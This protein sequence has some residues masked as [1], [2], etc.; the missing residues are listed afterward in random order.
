[1][2][3]LNTSTIN[4]TSK[5]RVGKTLAEALANPKISATSSVLLILM[6]VIIVGN[7]LVFRTVFVTRRLHFSAFYLVAS[8]AIADLMVGV[9]LLPLSIAYTIIGEMKG[10]EWSFSPVVCHAGTLFNFWFCC[11]SVFNL[12]AVS[13]DRYVAVTSPLLYTVRMDDAKVRWTIAVIWVVSL[14][15][16][17]LIM[18]AV[19]ESKTVF[20]CTATGLAVE[21]SLSSALVIFIIP[22]IFLVF[23]NGRIMS[24]ARAQLKKIKQQMP[25]GYDSYEDSSSKSRTEAETLPST[26]V[27]NLE[28]ITTKP[29]EP[30]QNLDF[31]ESIQIPNTSKVFEQSQTEPRTAQKQSD[32]L[33]GI[34]DTN[35]TLTKKLYFQRF[36][37]EFKTFKLFVIVTGVFLVCWTPLFVTMVMSS[38]LRTW[39]MVSIMHF[40]LILGYAN[41]A[42]NVFIYSYFNREFRNALL[43]RLRCFSGKCKPDSTVRRQYSARPVSA[44]KQINHAQDDIAR[45]THA[46][47]IDD[48]NANVTSTGK[49]TAHASVFCSETVTSP[50]GFPSTEARYISRRVSLVTSL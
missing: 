44:E 6:L 43:A 36:R 3:G 12:C 33:S 17:F 42:C 34:H 23:A 20:Y 22:L 48:I 4:S 7:T 45:D 26:T 16:S 14:F 10:G 5:P 40:A 18:V 15:M 19:I 25:Y 8:L 27:T 28:Q 39:T 35:S 38:F 46:S 29:Q 21:Y 30:E 50:E 47:A 37:R 24:I 31:Q 2:D 13:W 1:M 32:I 41:S 49:P 11:A 9:S